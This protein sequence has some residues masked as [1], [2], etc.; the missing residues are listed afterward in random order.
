MAGTDGGSLP[1]VPLSAGMS[2]SEASS[3]V[4]AG[5]ACLPVESPRHV[6][7]SDMLDDPLC[8]VSREE[9]RRRRREFIT[10]FIIA[11][12]R[13]QDKQTFRRL[14]QLFP[15]NS[16]DD[17][18]LYGDFFHCCR[19][20]GIETRQVSQRLYDKALRRRKAIIEEFV[21][22][23][24]DM[25]NLAMVPEIKKL[26]ESARLDTLEDRPLYTLISAARARLGLG[27]VT[28][29]PSSRKRQRR[30]TPNEGASVL[31]TSAPTATDPTVDIVLP[32]WWPMFTPTMDDDARDAQ[33]TASGDTPLI[34]PVAT[35]TTAVPLLDDDSDFSLDVDD[36]RILYEA[37]ESHSP[38][39]FHQE[40]VTAAQLGLI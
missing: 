37:L 6:P 23:N 1:D 12:N 26:L 16:V 9:S 4:Q 27:V 35:T 40:P 38:V 15:R 5:V 36:V 2:E 11:N 24:S 17:S 22:A 18:T 29:A 30:S 20:L 19:E 25:S 10:D 39:P 32:G 8:S 7:T 31:A 21:V 3:N 33:S 28:P 14:R 34:A 13:T